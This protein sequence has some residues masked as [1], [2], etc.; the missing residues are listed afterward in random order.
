MGVLLLVLFIIFIIVLYQK[1]MQASKIELANFEKDHQKK[2]LDASPEIAEQERQNIAVNLHDEVGLNLS[3][4]KINF[5]KLE[6]PHEQEVTESILATSY[7]LIENSMDIIRTIHKD[8]RPRTLMTLGLIAAIRELAREI[9]ISK[10]A[11]VIVSSRHEAVISDKN[12]EM[13]LYRLIKEVL[14][15]TLK[16]AK[17]AFI[18]IN[19]EFN[20]NNLIVTILHNGMGITTQR[21]EELAKNS[22]GLGLKSIFTRTE[23]LK[24]SL[25]FTVDNAERARVVL[26]C[27]LV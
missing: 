20:E 25:V 18:E 17:P 6:T 26:N 4:L 3:I 27:P 10:A 11:E 13:Q 21:I 1:R 19:I 23:L 5:S 14:N 22:K 9:N 12:I 15:N 7:A 8:I 24:A 16:H 2:L